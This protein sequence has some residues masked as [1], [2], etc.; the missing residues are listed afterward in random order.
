M[1]GG[2]HNRM[3][4]THFEMRLPRTADHPDAPA[5]G[6]GAVIHPC[7]PWPGAIERRTQRAHLSGC[8][9]TTQARARLM[10][11]SRRS[12]KTQRTGLAVPELRA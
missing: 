1:D 11:R 2:H 12:R 9:A 4:L 10:M 3:P 6:A 8:A 5:G 7:C